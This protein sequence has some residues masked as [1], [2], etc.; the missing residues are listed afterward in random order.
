LSAVKGLIISDIRMPQLDGIET[1]KKIRQLLQG[2]G[3]KPVPEIII[4]GYADESSYKNA[5]QLKVA[6][7]LYKPF[8]IKEFM[9]TIKRNLDAAQG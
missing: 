9:A 1:V 5:L 6:D 8:D 4:T 3:K 2:R 7:Y